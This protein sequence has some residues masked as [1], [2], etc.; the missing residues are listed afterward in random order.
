[1]DDDPRARLL[2][3]IQS[4]LGHLVHNATRIHALLRGAPDELPLTREQ[5]RL[6]VAPDGWPLRAL[7]AQ[8]S[9]QSPALRHALRTGL[10]L[11]IAY[12][13]ALPLP[14]ASHPHWLVLS[15]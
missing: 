7:R 13:L 1:D 11:G 14:W 5:L 4:R 3:A 9:F 12:F 6:F 15:V 8:R 2:P 10:A